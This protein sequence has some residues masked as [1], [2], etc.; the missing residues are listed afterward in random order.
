MPPKAT[1]KKTYSPP[2]FRTLNAIAAKATLETKAVSKDAGTGAMLDSIS[3]S[4]AKS[5]PNRFSNS[6]K[7]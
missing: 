6:R 7:T 2:S 1:A 4:K 5:G 3:N